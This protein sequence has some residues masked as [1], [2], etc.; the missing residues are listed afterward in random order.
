[1]RPFGDLTVETERLETQTCA[2]GAALV[3]A[4]T[5][6]ADEDR[7]KCSISV[8]W[9]RPGRAGEAGRGAKVVVGSGIDCD[10]VVSPGFRL[11]AR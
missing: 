5:D 7:E 10:F 6:R 11:L 2:R 4:Q 1:M 8:C 3:H 9:L